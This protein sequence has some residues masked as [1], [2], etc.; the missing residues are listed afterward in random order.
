MNVSDKTKYYFEK[1]AIDDLAEGSA[2]YRP[3]YI[4]PDYERFLK[5]GSEFLQLD[6]PRISTKPLM[7]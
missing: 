5:N 7:P 1:K 4:L 2:P 3:R 6:P